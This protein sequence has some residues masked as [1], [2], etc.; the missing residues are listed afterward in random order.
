LTD[1]V[2]YVE[3][4]A[5]QMLRNVGLAL[6]L[7]GGFVSFRSGQLQLDGQRSLPTTCPD[8]GELSL[9]RVEFNETTGRV[10]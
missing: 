1:Q 9:S 3:L 8:G 2:S 7:Q 6:V 4:V 10:S 5:P